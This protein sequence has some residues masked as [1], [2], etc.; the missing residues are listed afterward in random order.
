MNPSRLLLVAAV[1]AST[2]VQAEIPLAGR[3]QLNA[4]LW[5]QQ[6]TEYRAS[7]Q[8]TYAAATQQL[9]V[10]RRGGVAAVEQAMQGGY[11]SKK[12]IVVLD[13]DETVLDNSALNASLV[14]AGREL[15]PQ[16]W[17]QWVN[18]QQ[19]ALLPGAR[20]FILKARQQGLGVVFVSNRNCNAQGGYNAQGMALD[21]PQKSATLANLEH[22]LGYR[23][24]DD[25]LLL[26]DEK[27]G[28][29]DSDKTARRAEL[30]KT[31]RIALLIGDDLNDFIRAA[32]YRDAEHGKHWGRRWF[33]LPNPV[34]GS[35]QRPWAD[36]PGK[37]AALKAWRELPAPVAPGPKSL[38][39]ASWNL[40]W[41][42]DPQ[43]L[44]SSGF[45]QQCAAQNWPNKKLRDDLPYCDVY[46]QDKLLSA[47]DYQL[48]LHAV[49]A[50]L[51]ALAAQ[52]MDLLAVQE[53]QSPAALQAVLP[54]GFEVAC[55]TTRVDVQNIAYAVRSSVHL[56]FQCRE[57]PELSLENNDS[58]GVRRGLEL[59]LRLGQQELKLLNVHLK[60]RC[61]SGNMDNPKNSACRTLQRQMPALE[62]WIEAQAAAGKPFAI[63]GDWNRD[64]EGEVRRNLPARSDASD[65]A[66]PIVVPAIRNLFPEI[67]DHQPPAS[68]MVLAS[69]DRSAAARNACH[70]ALDQLV[71]SR[72]LLQ[73]LDQTS[74][75]TGLLPARLVKGPAA[76]SD[77]C[78]L[79]TQLTLP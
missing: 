51:E 3:E 15:N 70:K 44:I 7:T 36:V 75:N 18:E 38:G 16:L 61:A 57:V 78:A 24:R 21:C 74:L 58:G 9:S 50:G 47:D 49:K 54:D 34:Y 39:L 60:S 55:F 10:A 68:E 19:A 69:V 2:L 76:A 5:M 66:G 4:L 40:E 48:K 62:G 32:D 25:E 77:H 73:K 23:P 64:L 35:W 65:P 67:N 28:R 6:A 8:M 53:V 30:A 41:L 52:G 17:A 11:K 43:R 33:V 31:Y 29:D 12:P 71:L 79:Q 37:Y 56:P 59:S 14:Q 26:R 20:E 22:Q 63:I 27:Q 46:Q 13:I 42:S 72:T 45:W 1:L